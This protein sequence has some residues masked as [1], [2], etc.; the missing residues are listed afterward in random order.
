MFASG[1]TLS[2]TETIN[3]INAP[4]A[5]AIVIGTLKRHQ[6]TPAAKND[7]PAAIA[8]IMASS[9]EKSS[10]IKEKK[11]PIKVISNTMAGNAILRCL[12]NTSDKPQAIIVN[13]RKPTLVL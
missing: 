9:E 1:N 7:A 10:W 12:T 2:K 8:V 6:C 11:P 13:T 3:P 5:T 4:V